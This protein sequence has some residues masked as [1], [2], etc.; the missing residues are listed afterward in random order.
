MKRVR[1]YQTSISSCGPACLMM[2][3]K[4][5][6]PSFKLTR[7]NEW[8]IWRDSSLLAWT[9]CHP[10]GLAVAALKRGYRVR[11]IREKKAVWKDVYCP[12]NNEPM[13]FSL[14]LQEAEAKRLGVR[15][16]MKRR[17]EIKDLKDILDSGKSPLVLTKSIRKNGRPG[18]LHWIVVRE[19][20]GKFV[21][22]GNPDKEGISKIPIKTFMRMWDSIRDKKIGSAKE[23]IVIN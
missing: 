3:F 23:V 13:R 17:I 12:D 11:L 16:K 2:I 14:M 21:R 7:K 22:I 18:W 5:L 1:Y 10:Y 6:D 20:D 4:Q 8:D 19:I 15:E 9:G